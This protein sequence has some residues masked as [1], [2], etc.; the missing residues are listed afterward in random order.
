MHFN[1]LSYYCFTTDCS[2]SCQA[3]DWKARHKFACKGQ[4]HLQKG[5]WEKAEQALDK[6]IA[7][8]PPTGSLF[9]FRCE[10]RH[11]LQ[12]FQGAQKDA[13]K[14]LDLMSNTGATMF[15]CGRY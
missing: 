4:A 14:A 9:S 1:Y 8:Y 10:A 7:L 12:K 15:H 11:Q 6:A 13:Q 3:E 5:N 2:S